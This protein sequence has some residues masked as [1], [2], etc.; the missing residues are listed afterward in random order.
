MAMM[1][2]GFVHQGADRG[3]G[4]F[5]IVS[6]STGSSI[7]EQAAR[8]LKRVAKHTSNSAS[9]RL[10]LNK[11]LEVRRKVL[12]TGREGTNGRYTP[13]GKYI[14]VTGLVFTAPLFFPSSS[15][16]RLISFLLRSVL[17]PLA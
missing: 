7:A 14:K 16:S 15:I 8:N 12:A 4:V 3:M 1:E 13:G 5:I 6:L 17:P 10:W 11:K 2:R 9:H